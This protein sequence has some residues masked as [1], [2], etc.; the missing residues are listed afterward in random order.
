MGEAS[1]LARLGQENLAARPAVCRRETSFHLAEVERNLYQ[2]HAMP[3]IVVD[4]EK[5]RTLETGLGQFCLE[6]SRGL[7]AQRAA[8]D[9]LIFL[10]PP[11]AEGLVA[12]A[13]IKP[14]RRWQKADYHQHVGPWL[15]PLAPGPRYD[16]WHV[17]NQCSR[18]G[19][20]NPRTPVLLTIHDLNFLREKS[21]HSQ[22]SRLRA[23]QRRIDRATRLTAISR[24][25]A[26]EVRE[27]LNLRGKEIE[28]VYNGAATI[29]AEPGDRPAVAP[30][31][32]F[33]FSIGGFADKK[34]FHTLVPLIRRLPEFMLVI[35][36]FNNTEYGGYVRRLA[37]RL[38]VGDRLLTPGPVS[39]GERQWYYQHCAGFVFPSLTEGFG[40]PPIEAMSAGKPVFLS[41]RTSLPEVG[42][43]AAFYWDQFSP[44]A[45]ANVVRDGMKAATAPGF[46]DRVRAHADRFCWSR[47]AADYL[48]IYHEMTGTRNVGWVEPAA[49]GADPSWDRAA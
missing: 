31:T 39:D 13:R 26:G 9:D 20:W 43:A 35:A 27:H 11:G 30:A 19:P 46:E 22:A 32:P 10:T 36:G 41:T 38:G 48:R 49:A 18:Y 42:G 1:D 21:K 6:L 23:M 44:R 16:L 14:V 3:R 12:G 4:L 15:A 5:L 24:F 25:V 34:N 33:L 8:D 40:L 45:M 7:M 47:A 28:V 29:G 17:T 2:A 37:E